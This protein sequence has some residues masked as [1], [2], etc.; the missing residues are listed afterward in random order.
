MIRTL[1]WLLFYVLTLGLANI[2]VTYADGLSIR[3]NSWLFKRK[4]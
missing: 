3:L 4:P 2:D 1:F